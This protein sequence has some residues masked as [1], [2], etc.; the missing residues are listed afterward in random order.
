MDIDY[1]VKLREAFEVVA[2]YLGRDNDLTAVD[3]ANMENTPDRVARAFME[4]TR[5]RTEI[6]QEINHIIETAFPAGADGLHMPGMIV[7]GPIEVISLCPHHWLNVHY[8]IFVGYIPET[9]GPVL[10]LSKLA[11]LAIALGKR[12]VLQEDL[13]K[14]IANVLHCEV[15]RP[16]PRTLWP[17]IKSSGS[18]VRVIGKHSCMSCRGVGSNARTVTGERRGVFRKGNMELTF[19]TLVED[20]RRYQCE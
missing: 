4:M 8:E 18:I 5:T 16:Q 15:T 14:D 10:G 3:R 6:T 17:H 9:N 1:R 12:P 20:A 2:D 13:T 7:Q 11:R 19:N